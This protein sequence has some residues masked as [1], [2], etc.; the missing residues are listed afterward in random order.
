[1]L[2]SGLLM[3]LAIS[4]TV[5][6]LGALILQLKYNLDYLTSEVSFLKE[7]VKDF[8]EKVEHLSKMS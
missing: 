6:I 3:A 4:L 7:K 5:V 8:K 2:V 1:M